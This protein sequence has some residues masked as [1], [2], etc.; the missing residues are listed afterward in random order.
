MSNAAIY[1]H[2]NAFD[3]TGK[4]LLGRHSAGES[5][6]RG[7]M[8]HADVDGFHFWNVGGQ[9]QAAMDALV[10]RIE[11]PARPVRWI[12]MA[13]RHQLSNPGV[14]SISSPSLDT[15]AF[16]R[17]PFGSRAYALCGL[18]HTTAT[19]NVMRIL[20]DLLI[21]P[22]EGHDA[23]ICTSSAVR[24]AVEAQLDMMR[25]YMAAEYGPRRRPEL[26]RTTI[27]LGVNAADFATTPQR[28]A[29]WR[30]RLDIP[31]DA[32]VAL[33]VGRFSVKVK[34]NPA[35][36]AMALERA[37]QRTG[38][39]LYW[40]N[41]GWVEPASA[42]ATF[43]AEVRKLC[44]SVTYI[45]VDGRQPDVRFSIWSVADAFISFSDNIQETFGLTPIEAMAAGLPSVVS[46]WD[47]YKDTVRHG[48]DGFRI[49][50]VAPR[51]GYGGDLA[52]WFAN[53]W[54]NY[55]NYVGATAQYTAVDLAAAEAAL[56]ALIEDE[57]LR[58][59]MGAAARARA[60]EVFDWQAIIPQYQALWAEQNARRLAAGPDTLPRLNPYR[61]DPY[62]LFAG[63]PSRHLQQRDLVALRPGM[64]W[65]T[66]RVRLDAPLAVYSRFNRP[67][68][69]ELERVFGR[70]AQG[71]ATVLELLD[72]VAQAR[73][74][75]LERGLIWLARH[76]VVT[77]EAVP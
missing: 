24:A 31:A 71:P 8:R 68:A 16:H 73:R 70:L 22:V 3:T 57:G 45:D 7:Y 74:N 43:H 65:P 17:Q 76:D 26:M 13:D 53:A 33:Y 41:S 52:Y 23:L 25:A 35:L 12:G 6:L 21:A 61:P 47:G 34:M 38:K 51:P 19:A 39:P 62:T 50:T 44:P 46:D 15:E 28:R 72:L 77:L 14:V 48:V 36:M 66:A 64:D 55:D 18:T 1:L 30:E 10:Q 40:V 29:A 27:P 11:P 2:P 60:R 9:P 32:F 75:Y 5:F 4:V 69:Q 54:I 42:E 56:V 63:Y 37:A 49:P 58:R 67:N 20:P 59:T